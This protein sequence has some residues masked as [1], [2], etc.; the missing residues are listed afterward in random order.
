MREG[1]IQTAGA[2][3]RCPVFSRHHGCHHFVSLWLLEKILT[4]TVDFFE[5]GIKFLVLYK[6]EDFGEVLRLII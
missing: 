1:G 5:Y 2:G 6:F 4:V 3:A